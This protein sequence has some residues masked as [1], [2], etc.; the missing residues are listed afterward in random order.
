MDLS[1]Q[2]SLPASLRVADLPPPVSLTRVDRQAPDRPAVEAFV[3]DTFAYYY[4]ARVRVLP[5]C[6]LALR[7]AGGHITAVA[8][9]RFA[10][11][12]PLFLEQYLDAPIETCLDTAGRIAR[13]VIVEIGSLAAPTPGQV[14]YMM[15]ALTGYLHSA[16]YRWVACTAINS[17][18][19]TL[20]RM[21]LTPILLGAADPRRL[22]A[23]AGDWGSYYE[24]QPQVIAGHLTQAADLLKTRALCPESAVASLWRSAR[25]SGRRDR[26]G[27]FSARAGSLAALLAG[28][29]GA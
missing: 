26:S 21:G 12:G 5:D 25:E 3:R 2:H 24:K 10:A 22:G 11:A 27:Q 1:P 4:K 17:L 6:L 29:L 18:R 7:L 16:G 28:S 20:A 14:R 15:I 23:G 19:N 9:L 8:G 13:G